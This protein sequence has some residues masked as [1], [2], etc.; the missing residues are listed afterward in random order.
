[1]KRRNQ[2]VLYS[3]PYFQ[4]VRSVDLKQLNDMLSRLSDEAGGGGGSGGG[5]KW[6][7]TASSSLGGGPASPR[8]GAATAAA[9]AA[10]GIGSHR[11]TPQ[12]PP[13][14]NYDHI[15][16][17]NLETRPESRSHLHQPSY[18]QQ[19]AASLLQVADAAA[20]A[21]ANAVPLSI[22]VGDTSLLVTR[23]A[24]AAVAAATPEYNIPHHH[25]PSA[26]ILTPAV[27]LPVAG[28]PL[29]APGHVAQFAGLSNDARPASRVSHHHYLPLVLKGRWEKKPF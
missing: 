16:P 4:F 18:V 19:G 28:N 14:P 1:M 9:A 5:G 25:L 21:A 17:P 11:R 6:R 8:G 3:V 22:P 26:A 24:A 7:T 12:L 29:A 20:A 27:P 15:L 13:H 10:A 2:N 23:N